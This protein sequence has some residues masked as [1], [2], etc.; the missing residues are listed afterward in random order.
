MYYNNILKIIKWFHCQVTKWYLCRNNN[1]WNYHIQAKQPWFNANKSV[2]NARLTLCYLK[3]SRGWIFRHT[4]SLATM[5]FKETAFECVESS[6][7]VCRSAHQGMATFHSS[8]YKM[9][10][11]ICILK[12][13]CSNFSQGSLSTS[14][15]YTTSVIRW[16]V[17]KQINANRTL[18]VSLHKG[19]FY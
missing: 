13:S 1:W 7:I 18:R 17:P 6:L 2:F 15:I 5:H 14:G 12:L 11:D 10:P 4:V 9:I 16:F 3:S 8:A 19:P